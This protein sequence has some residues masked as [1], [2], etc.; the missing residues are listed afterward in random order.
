MLL[1]LPKP[2]TIARYLRAVRFGIPAR[3]ERRTY[4]R[5][6]IFR[7][8]EIDAGLSFATIRHRRWEESLR[9]RGLEKVRKLPPGAPRLRAPFERKK[10]A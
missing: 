1:D 10:A 2:E 3:F 5:P 4:F 6:F 9:A 8:D 7:K